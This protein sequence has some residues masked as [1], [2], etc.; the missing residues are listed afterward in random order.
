MRYLIASVFTYV[1]LLLVGLSLNESEESFF[2]GWKL[3]LFPF[4]LVLLFGFAA[5]PLVVWVWATQ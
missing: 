5:S 2:Q 1:F 4:V 3:L